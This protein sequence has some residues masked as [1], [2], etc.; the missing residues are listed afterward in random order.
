M[1]GATALAPPDAVVVV[2]AT[3]LQVDALEGHLDEVVFLQVDDA[4]ATARG[5]ARDADA[6]GGAAAAAAAYETRY[7]AACRIYLAERDPAARAGVL[8]DHDDPRHP[9]VVRPASL[10][11]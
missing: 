4:V 7:A 8:I 9:R 3:F 11:R 2:D 6:L 10:R 5:V 1:E